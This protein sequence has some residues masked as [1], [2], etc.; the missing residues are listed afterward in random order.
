MKQ[1]HWPQLACR[2]G[3]PDLVHHAAL[4]WRFFRGR[5]TSLDASVIKK[6]AENALGDYP[7]L[8]VSE[9]RFL[10]K[11]ASR[12][13]LD[14]VRFEFARSAFQRT[15]DNRRTD[16]SDVQEF[17]DEAES[18]FAA[19]CSQAG[20]ELETTGAPAAAPGGNSSADRKVAGGTNTTPGRRGGQIR[21]PG[22]GQLVNRPA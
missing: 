16:G 5:L 7:I 3:I 8:T 11:I 21:H 13:R 9:D 15:I 1:I 14:L 17:Y 20:V 4:S 12:Y 19:W 18:C 22:P 2:W 10:R 6:L